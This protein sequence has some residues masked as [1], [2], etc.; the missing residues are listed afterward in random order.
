MSVEVAVALVAAVASLVV[1]LVSLGTAMLTNRQS[2]RT[3]E[4][5]ETMKHAFSGKDKAASIADEDLAK[6]M[7]SLRAGLEAIQHVRD[8]LQLILSSSGESLYTSIALKRFAV[9]REE[10]SKAYEGHFMNL[11]EAE[12]TAFHKAK[13]ATLAAERALTEGLG[14]RAYVS[15]LDETAQSK[16][17]T[18]RAELADLQRI[19]LDSKVNRL[20]RRI[21]Q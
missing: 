20:A 15:E 19:L 7:E 18:M 9:A 17:E 8:E 11:D 14:S 16:C 21:S 10:M 2:A 1:A 4:S 3:A 6:A 12:R 5:I 13:N